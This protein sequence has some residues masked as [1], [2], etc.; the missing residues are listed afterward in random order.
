MLVKTILKL[1]FK[2]LVAVIR[3]RKQRLR[4]KIVFFILSRL[5]E[6]T[7]L[8]TRIRAPWGG[9]FEMKRTLRICCHAMQTVVC[10]FFVCYRLPS[11]NSP[12]LLGTHHIK[13]PMLNLLHALINKMLFLSFASDSFPIP[14]RS[15]VHRLRCPVH[16]TLSRPAPS[17]WLAICN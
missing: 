4:L 16:P 11:G 2:F 1:L 15:Q 9:H 17:T 5:R 12:R 10:K 6:T 7:N 8:R 3:S 14:L 13:K